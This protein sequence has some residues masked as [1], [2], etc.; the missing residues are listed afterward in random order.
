LREATIE[1]VPAIAA[2]HRSGWR[3]GYGHLFTPDILERAIEKHCSRWPVVFRDP[4][5]RQTTM[6]VVESEEGLTGFAH[7][8]PAEDERTELYSFYVDP[9]HWGDGTAVEM[10]TGVR[11]ILVSDGL[12]SVYLTTYGGVSRARRF[13]EKMGFRETGRVID[14]YLLNEVH[15]P[16][17][18]YV[19]HLK[20]GSAEPHV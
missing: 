4:D 20:P 2:L 3:E 12:T 1:D 6:L 18:E 13:Y 17:I 5:F 7:F 14:Y 15:V 9:S 19:C 8:G 11:A 16:Q 10:M